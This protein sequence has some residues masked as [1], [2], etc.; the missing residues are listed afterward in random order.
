MASSSD[1]PQV[2]LLHA[3]LHALDVGQRLRTGFFTVYRLRAPLS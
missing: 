2:G 3:D 1:D